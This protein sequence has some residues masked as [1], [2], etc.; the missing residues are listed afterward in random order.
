M[1]KVFHKEFVIDEKGEKKAV[2]IDFKDYKKM[3]RLLEEAECVKII[4]EGEQEYRQ[5]KLKPIKS[6]AALD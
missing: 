3:L 1:R 5:G 2:I 6:L 4:N